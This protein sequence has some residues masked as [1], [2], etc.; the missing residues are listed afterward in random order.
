MRNTT[1]DPE[2]I[3]YY[4]PVNVASRNHPN[5]TDTRADFWLETVPQKD[6]LITQD[7]HDASPDDWIIVN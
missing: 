6:F 4:I 5:F 1:I 2:N 7:F 3:L